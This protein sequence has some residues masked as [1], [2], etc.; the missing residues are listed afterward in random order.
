MRLTPSHRTELAGQATEL[1]V[2]VADVE[3]VHAG[4]L[5]ISLCLLRGPKPLHNLSVGAMLYT[6]SHMPSSAQICSKVPKYDGFPT[7]RQNTRPPS[8]VTT[9]H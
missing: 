7:Y 4:R 5:E 8:L 9:S 1:F 6:V 3:L 2:V